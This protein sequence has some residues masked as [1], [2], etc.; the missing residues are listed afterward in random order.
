MI[1]QYGHR[2]LQSYFGIGVLLLFEGDGESP[3]LQP[4]LEFTAQ[5]LTHY[6]ADQHRLHYAAAGRFGYAVDDCHFHF[7]AEGRLHFTLSEED[8]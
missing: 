2:G 5:G 4:G 6:T 8:A 7:T 3:F 1:I